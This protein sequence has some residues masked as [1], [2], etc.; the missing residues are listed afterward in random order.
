MSATDWEL[1]FESG[2]DNAYGTNE[3]FVF[4]IQPENDGDRH[5]AA[6]FWEMEAGEDVE[7]TNDYVRGFAEGA[8][9]V[10]REIKDKVLAR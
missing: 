7:L 4:A 10:W 9:G 2:E 8:L 3:S 1:W 5:A 6:S